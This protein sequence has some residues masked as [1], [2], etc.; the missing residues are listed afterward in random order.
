MVKQRRKNL[1]L[2]GIEILAHLRT[3]GRNAS[4]K[5][6]DH[7]NVLEGHRLVVHFDDLQK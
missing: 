6:S 5:Q 1:F 4:R 3:T 2:V 7:Y